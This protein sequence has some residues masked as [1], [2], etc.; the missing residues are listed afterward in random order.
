M[1]VL[2]GE[3]HQAEL[4]SWLDIILQWKRIKIG[5]TYIWLNST[6]IGG[7]RRI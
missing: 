4:T 6:R 1:F 2:K 5:H 3:S 7:N